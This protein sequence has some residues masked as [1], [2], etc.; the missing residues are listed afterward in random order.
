MIEVRGEVLMKRAD[1][2][3]LNITQADKGEKQFV[4]KLTQTIS[5]ERELTAGGDPRIKLAQTACRRIA[6]IGK[7][8]LAFIRLL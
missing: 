5:K 7:L 3:R 1:F 6:R 4:L 8:F 2:G